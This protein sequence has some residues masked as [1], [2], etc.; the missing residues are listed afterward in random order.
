MTS[1]VTSSK[2]HSFSARLGNRTGEVA[3]RFHVTAG[4]I[5]RLRCELATSWRTFVAATA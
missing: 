5:G 3:G 2:K 1:L 4:R